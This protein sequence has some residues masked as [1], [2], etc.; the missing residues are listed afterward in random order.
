ML[1]FLSRRPWLLVIVAFAILIA[2][3]I[4]IIR[5]SKIPG[6]QPLPQATAT[7]AR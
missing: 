5:I 7:P 1:G 2:A 3:W 6:T 4:S